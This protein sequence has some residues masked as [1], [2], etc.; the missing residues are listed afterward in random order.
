MNLEYENNFL[1]LEDDLGA[2]ERVPLTEIQSDL[3]QDKTK[4]YID[5]LILSSIDGSQLAPFFYDL[6][7][8]HIIYF[9]FK[10]HENDLFLKHLQDVCMNEFSLQFY[11]EIFNNKSI[12]ESFNHAKGIMLTNIFNKYRNFIQELKMFE[13]IL[14]VG[15]K[16]YP[17]PFI[18]KI[19]PK[20]YSLGRLDDISSVKAPTNID[21]Y[22]EIIL[23]RKKDLYDIIRTLNSRQ[24][25]NIYGEKGIG[26]TKFSKLV[27]YYALRLGF[28]DGVFYFKL[29]DLRKRYN[30]DLR[31]LMKTV[32]GEE[33]AKEIHFYFKNKEMLLV[34]DDYDEILKNDSDIYSYTHIFHTLKEDNIPY[35]VITKNKVIAKKFIDRI[36]LYHKLQPLDHSEAQE[37]LEF[38]FN[39]FFACYQ[40]D[41]R[42]REKISEEIKMIIEI[43]KGYPKPLIKRY[44]ELKNRL[45]HNKNPNSPHML[46]KSPFNN[47]NSKG[48]NQMKIS[49]RST[50]D[51]S[52]LSEKKKGNELMQPIAEENEKD[53][54]S[55]KMQAFQLEEE[56]LKLKSTMSVIEEKIKN[57]KGI[58]PVKINKTISYSP[59]H[60][61]ARKNDALSPN[62]T[63][64]FDDFSNNSQTEDSS[65]DESY[66]KNLR[67]KN[68]E[69][70]EEFTEENKDE[71]DDDDDDDDDEE[72]N[73]FNLEENKV[74]FVKSL[75]ND[76]KNVNKEENSN[77]HDSDDPSLKKNFS[78]QIEN[79]IKKGRITGKQGR[80]YHKKKKN[81]FKEGIKV[82][83][84]RSRSEMNES[85]AE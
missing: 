48:K 8:L 1:M 80:K 29:G 4:T 60:A 37:F 11:E 13:K 72:D 10:P 66:Q 27:G 45:F 61:E 55:R 26:K 44:K 35:I 71:E 53:W 43:S 54:K 83:S 65:D 46:H 30:S 47:R 40:I 25:V 23:G 3:Q 15:P 79:K 7:I 85:E 62:M 64:S 9:E 14:G 21:K 69:D 42:K 18:E 58:K 16:L 74:K 49:N 6:G 57:K 50:P 73:S 28:K 75:S 81:K 32:F 78:E 52:S 41:E 36:A 24:C 67:E 33:F 56:G 31:E 38:K 70:D 22:D 39:E 84:D 68:S 34:F 82:F 2:L 51:L 19:N 17:D 5:I 76:I 63:N 77:K 59:Q 12:F 20:Q